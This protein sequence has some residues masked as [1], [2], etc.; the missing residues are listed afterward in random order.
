MV[1][2][3]RARAGEFSRAASL[4]HAFKQQF[5]SSSS[6][7]TVNSGYFP[8]LTLVTNFILLFPDVAV[9]SQQPLVGNTSSVG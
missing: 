9:I 4:P 5:V 7:F 6:M 2:P 1:K 8:G 3:R